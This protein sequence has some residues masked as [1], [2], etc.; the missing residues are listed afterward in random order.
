[1]FEVVFLIPSS[2][3]NM[4]NNRAKLSSFFC[5]W[6]NCVLSVFICSVKFSPSIIV[7]RVLGEDASLKFAN[8]VKATT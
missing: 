4:Q 7:K 8:S 1:M 2:S 5:C 6:K 3:H